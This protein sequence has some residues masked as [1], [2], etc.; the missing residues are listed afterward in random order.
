[1]K[2]SN[3]EPRDEVAYKAAE[4]I[5][6]VTSKGEE[7]VKLA[8]IMA[9]AGMAK[10]LANTSSQSGKIEMLRHHALYL[11]IAARLEQEVF[12]MAKRMIEDLTRLTDNKDHA[13]MLTR[14]WLAKVVR[15]IVKG[16]NEYEQ[17]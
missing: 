8:T 3:S 17:E 4:E 7:I 10:M 9:T 14:I 13:E 6:Q 5:T 15:D 11:G 1:V 2:K 16:V 12:P